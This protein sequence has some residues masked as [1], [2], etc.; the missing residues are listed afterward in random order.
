MKLFA[1][2]G[3]ETTSLRSVK[4]D[5]P[6]Q[7]FFIFLPALSNQ[8]KRFQKKRGCPPCLLINFLMR[9]KKYPKLKTVGPF[10]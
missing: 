9:E 4:L 3:R 8:G 6:P 10:F 2:F 1:P 7:P 5:V